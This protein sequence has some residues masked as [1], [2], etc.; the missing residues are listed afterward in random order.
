M[1]HSSMHSPSGKDFLRVFEVDYGGSFML[2][3]ELIKC[4]ARMASM[5]YF[6]EF[7]FRDLLS[8]LH[9]LSLLIIIEKGQECAGNTGG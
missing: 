9:R 4:A 3:V 5:S 8:L 1:L 6:G 2:N 7:G